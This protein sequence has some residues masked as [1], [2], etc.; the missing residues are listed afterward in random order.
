VETL[1]TLQYANRATNIEN[2]VVA[3][4]DSQTHL[5]TELPVK[6][7]GVLE[8]N[9]VYLEND[10]LKRDLNNANYRIEELFA[11]LEEVTSENISL[12]EKG[13]LKERG[14]LKEIND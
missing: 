5:I 9:D 13:Y 2:K 12:K 1:N 11:R 3:N 6:D 8:L 10:M 7:D 14:Y 4:Q